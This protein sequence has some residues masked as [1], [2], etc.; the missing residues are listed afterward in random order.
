LTNWIQ[1]DAVTG[2]GFEWYRSRNT[3]SLEFRYN[4]GLL[5]VN[6]SERYFL[7]GEVTGLL[8]NDFYVSDDFRL[9]VFEISFIASY[10][11]NNK[12]FKLR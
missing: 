5:D 1:V 7:G 4:Y 3:Y 8:F 10:V 12:A 11:L 2:F 6:S 9:Q